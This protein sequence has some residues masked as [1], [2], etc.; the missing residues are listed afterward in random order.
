MRLTILLITI[1][2]C[3]CKLNLLL[4]QPENKTISNRFN[5]GFYCD[6]TQYWGNNFIAKTY[7]PSF[8][9]VFD[10]N[11]SLYK[12]I[13]IG[14]YYQSGTYDVKSTA[15][16]GNS[17]QGEINLFGG[18]ISYLH[19]FNRR[20]AIVPR[21]SL[22]NVNV[23]N[24]LS[25]LNGITSYGYSTDYGTMLSCAPELHFFVNRGISFFAN[26][27]FEYIWFTG[28]N[29]NEQLGVSYHQSIAS[30][31]GLGVRFWNNRHNFKYYNKYINN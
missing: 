9:G 7:S 12:N 4:A 25:S 23:N 30:G 14:L 11:I 5:I 22:T 17:K 16:I 21:I 27:N 13:A 3:F 6:Y 24:G 1:L 29:V 20:W 26:C 19:Q 10:F 15:F 8:P 31:I 18:D 28:I 2:L